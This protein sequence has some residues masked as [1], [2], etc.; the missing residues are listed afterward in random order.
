MGILD[1]CYTPNTENQHNYL[2]DSCVFDKRLSNSAD[3]VNLL[4]E[5]TKQGYKEAH[6]GDGVN[7]CGRMKYQRGNVQ[8]QS[9]QSVT[10]NGGNER[11]VVLDEDKWSDLD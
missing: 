3:D 2:L 6:D 4:I 11:G 10:T 8:E 7:I 9:T 1:K 5:A